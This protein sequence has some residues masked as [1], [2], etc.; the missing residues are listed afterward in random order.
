MLENDLESF[1]KTHGFACCINGVVS[2][3]S[4]FTKFS[5]VDLSGVD[6]SAAEKSELLRI[7]QSGVYL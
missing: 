5:A 3:F 1:A 4:G 6:L 7:L 2:D